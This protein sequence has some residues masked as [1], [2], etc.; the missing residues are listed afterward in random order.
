MCDLVT[1]PSHFQKCDTIL[2]LSIF[3]RCLS[4]IFN[5]FDKIGELW[6]VVGNRSIELDPSFEKTHVAHTYTWIQKMG[7]S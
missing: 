4:F 5:N 3:R 6:I 2:R 7:S 1:L